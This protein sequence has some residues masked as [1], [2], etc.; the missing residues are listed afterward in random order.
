M[1]T[2]NC[3]VM[4]TSLINQLHTVMNECTTASHV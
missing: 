4:Q 2:V 1:N 3:F